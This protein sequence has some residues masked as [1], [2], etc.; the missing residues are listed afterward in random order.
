MHWKLGLL[1]QAEFHDQSGITLVVLGVQVVQQ[2]AATAHHT[3]QTAATVVVFGVQLEV[4][5]SSLI[6]AVSSA[7]C[8]SGLPVS[9]ALRALALTTS[10]LIEDAIMFYP[11]K[12]DLR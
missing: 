2:L 6:R 12:S 5:V 10:A 8:T 1:T 9:V 4:G 11:F 3:Q 7:T